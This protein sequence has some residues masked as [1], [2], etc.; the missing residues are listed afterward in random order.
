MLEPKIHDIEIKQG[1]QY[2]DAF[3]WYGG[4]KVCA[5]IENVIVGCPTQI[6][7]TGHTLPSVSKTPIRIRNVRGARDLNTGE[8]DCDMVEATWIDANTFSVDIDTGNQTYKAGSGSIEWFKPKVVTGY[9]ARMQI[10][11][12][13]TDTV[14]LVSLVSP[15]DIVINVADAKITFTIDT[16]ATTALDFIQGVY[17]LELV[18]PSGAATRLLQGKVTLNK[19][20]TR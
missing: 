6:T 17:D 2:Q 5:S 4:G 7:I 9:T 1:A 15:A 18:D 11:E 20:V 19:E 10:R 12:K 16:T 8:Q 3:H 14:A 13:L